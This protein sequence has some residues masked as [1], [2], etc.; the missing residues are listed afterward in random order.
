MSEKEIEKLLVRAVKKAGGYAFKFVS[1]G[2]NGVPDRLVVLPGN[3]IGFV[4]L[5][6][7][8]KIPRPEQNYQINRLKKFG[9]CVLVVDSP[10]DIEGAIHEIGSWLDYGNDLLM[11]VLEAGGLI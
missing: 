8:G 10:E 6:A 4:E 2:T 9:C 1:P 5:K 11:D 3:H 7:T